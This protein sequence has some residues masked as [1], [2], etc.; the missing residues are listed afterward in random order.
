M[1]G[2]A[3]VISRQTRKQASPE[4][5]FEEVLENPE[6]YTG[7]V[8]ILSGVITETK[9]TKE[10]TL[11]EVLQIP[12]NYRGKPADIEESK[13]RF[14]VIDERFLDPDIYTKWR[15]ITVAGEI[16]GKRTQQMGKTEYT[17]PFIQAT[18]IYLWPIERTYYPYR[19]RYYPYDYP[20][21]SY[22]AFDR[23]YW[24]RGSLLHPRRIPRKSGDIGRRE[25][26]TEK[27]KPRT[28][29]KIPRGDRKK[30]PG[31]MKGAGRRKGR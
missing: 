4:I 18:E 12:A 3:H 19:Y 13:G 8:I 31:G 22:Y 16:L 30:G 21:S 25:P 11:L 2:C 27:K 17:Y 20:Y 23:Y 6:D 14:L 7:E 10:G 5:T 9:N 15:S 29:R 26:D 1:A 24:R 28:D